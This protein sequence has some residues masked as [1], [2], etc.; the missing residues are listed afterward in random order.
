MSQTRLNG[1]QM[2]SDRLA[3]EVAVVKQH[4]QRHSALVRVVDAQWLRACSASCGRADEDAYVLGLAA[5]MPS[6]HAHA[7]EL[8]PEQGN[9]GTS[10]SAWDGEPCHAMPLHPSFWFPCWQCF[11]SGLQREVLVC[12]LSTHERCTG[13]LKIRPACMPRQ[14]NLESSPH[15]ITLRHLRVC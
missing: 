13:D 4:Q 7:R 5:L 2:G 1:L 3:N 10:R 11:Q 8:G 9:R 14:R 6:T 15:L 12:T